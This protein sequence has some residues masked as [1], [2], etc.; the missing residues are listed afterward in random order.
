MSDCRSHWP[1]DSAM[2][3]QLREGV[4]LDGSRSGGD[5][6][7]LMLEFY[8]DQVRELAYRLR[9]AVVKHA[10]ILRGGDWR[11]KAFATEPHG[12]TRSGKSVHGGARD[13][14]KLR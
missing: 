5:G 12:G 6:G 10:R 8:G 13:D 2:S 1:T 9:K 11:G 7:G 14:D 3:P 4:A